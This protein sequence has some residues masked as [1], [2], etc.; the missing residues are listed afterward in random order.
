M[1]KLQSLLIK[2][3]QSH[4]NDF[5][6]APW[7]HQYSELPF[8]KYWEIVYNIIQP[9]GKEKSIIEIGCGLGDVTAIFCYLGFKKILSFEKN[10]EIAKKAKRRMREMFNRDEII[11]NSEFPKGGTYS[12]D[13]LVLV[14]CAYADLADS[15]KAYLELMMKYYLAAGKPQYFIMEVIDASYTEE[16]TE[17]PKYIRMSYE[18][19]VSLFPDSEITSWETYKY[20]INKKSKTLYLIK[21]K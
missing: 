21:S 6:V 13:I 9:K 18:D 20:P 2:Y 16:N 1:E 11:Q 15:K 3:N 12:S 19:V 8:P 7:S 4:N 17:F 10:E 14:N 5:E